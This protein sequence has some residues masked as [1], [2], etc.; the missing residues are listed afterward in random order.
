MMNEKQDR[1]SFIKKSNILPAMAMTPGRLLSSV[2]EEGRSIS[3][4]SEAEYPDE[5]APGTIDHFKLAMIQMYVE[6]AGKEANLDRAEGLMREVAQNGANIALLPE[7]MDLGWTDP[8]AR[9]QADE[10]PGGVT[11]TILSQAAKKNK[12]FVY[13]GAAEKDGNAVYNSAVIIN[14]SGRVVLKHWKP[15]ELDIGQ[16]LYTDGDRLNVCHTRY[17]TLGLMICADATAK[18]HVLTRSLCYMGADVILSPSSWA[19]PPDYNNKKTPYR[20][21]WRNAYIP[22]AH[23]FSVWIAG[24]SNVG[25]IRAGAWKNWNCIGCSLVIDPYRN[26]IV[27]GPYGEKAETIIYVDVTPVKRP[28]W[29]MGWDNYKPLEKEN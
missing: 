22:A 9:A 14:D 3:G 6:L 10:I 21:T 23:E 12:I 8:P 4:Q 13:S 24:C 15:N 5:M 27:Q 7:V 19:V 1:R 18:E 17:G 29:G 25:P 2:T 26:E 16:G 28:T 20:D 11:C